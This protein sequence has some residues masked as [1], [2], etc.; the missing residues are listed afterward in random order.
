[1]VRL[2]LSTYEQKIMFIPILSERNKNTYG[3]DTIHDWKRAEVMF[4]VLQE[5]GE[6]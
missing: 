3:I 4:K 5:M 2:D 6:C 1:M